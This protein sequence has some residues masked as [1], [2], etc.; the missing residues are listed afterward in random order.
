MEEL[1]GI[2]ERRLKL[3]SLTA[4]R[5]EFSSKAVEWLRTKFGANLRTMEYFLYDY[6]QSEKPVGSIRSDSL[7][8]ALGSFKPPSVEGESGTGIWG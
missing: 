5:P 4:E 6:F 1:A 8:K 2:L 3:F 7:E